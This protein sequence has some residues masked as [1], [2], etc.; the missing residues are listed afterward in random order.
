MGGSAFS[1]GPDPL[2]TPRMPK[3]VYLSVKAQCQ[4][5][6]REHYICVAS[7]IDGPGKQDFGDVDIFVCLPKDSPSTL[8][9]REHVDFLGSTIGAVRTIYHKN[10]GIAGNYAIPWPHD[11][12]QDG[13]D[14]ASK[15]YIQVD[16]R[17]C[18]SFERLSWMLFKHAHADFWN[19]VGS[20]IRPYGLT[21][22]D[23]AFW[24]RIPEIEEHNKKLAKIFLTIEP[25]HVLDFLGLPI[26]SN[27][28]QTHD[29]L[30][31]QFEYAATCNL[32]YIPPDKSQWEVKDLK[33]ND[34]NRARKRPGFRKWIEEFIP[35]CREQGRFTTRP[36]TREAVTQRALERFHVADEYICR[37][38]AYLLEK[39]RDSV[40]NDLIKV[41]IPA[42]EEGPDE[43]AVMYRSCTVRA[44][45]AIILERSEEFGVQFDSSLVD[46]RGF[47]DLE[48]LKRFIEKHHKVVG[49]A[50]LMKHNSALEAH[51]RKKGKWKETREADE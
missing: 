15:R 40:W 28:D 19:Y 7:P 21:V 49:E 45:K 6:L 29:S 35:Q 23:H 12:A 3:D 38:D 39:H 22:D 14:D 33:A 50:A 37:R 8:S 17:L 48:G 32:M 16:V 41:E 34:R 2:E 26:E 11:D 1:S 51:L 5:R 43:K 25:A 42:P 24:V 18:E 4:A 13:S 10:D 9:E 44:F 30:Q 20:T 47:Y 36:T 27:W 31:D 46:H